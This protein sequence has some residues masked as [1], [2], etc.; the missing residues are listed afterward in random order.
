MQPVRFRAGSL[1]DGLP[2]RDL[3]VSPEHAM[4][5]DGVLVPARLLLNGD[6]IV[7]ETDLPTVEYFHVE[8]ASHDVLLA[9]GAPS[10]TF[11]DCDSRGMFQNAHTFAGDAPRWSFCA[12]RVEDG[13]VLARINE[14]LRLRVHAAAPAAAFGHLDWATHDGCAG[15]AWVPGHPEATLEVEVLVD[16]SP[17]ARAVANAWRPDV[18]AQGLGTGRYG[19]SLTFA[20]SLPRFRRHV[21][22]ARAVTGGDLIGAAQLDAAP[23]F[24][25]ASLPALAAAL[26]AH[27][28]TRE[29]ARDVTRFLIE[30]LHASRNARH[31]RS[32]APLAL[33]L[34]HAVPRPTE[35]AGSAAIV[36]HM[37]SL[38][39]LGYQVAFVPLD[40]SS[41][42]LPEGVACA[43]WPE[44]P[45]VEDA[46]RQ[47]GDAALVY[48]HRVTSM[49][50]YG[51]L[52]RQACPGARLVYAV[53]D[54]HFLRLGRQAVVEHSA[55]RLAESRRSREQELAAS[56]LAD[57]TLTH[58]AAE[59]ELL[60]RLLPGISARVV[61]WHVP[62]GPL[63]YAW[64]RRRNLLFVGGLAH[65]PNADALRWLASEI[66]PRI[67]GMNPRLRCK[68]VGVGLTE[69][70]R[71]W[72]HPAMDV[73][74][75]VQ[76]I[77]RVYRSA[78]V[79]LAPLRFGAGVKGKVLE[80]FA[81]I[82]P[83]AMTPIAAEGL[84]LPEALRPLVAADADAFAQLVVALHD[85]PAAN[86]AAGE[87]GRALVTR[88]TSE[89]V[90]DA[91][92]A[93][94]AASARA[95]RF[96]S[97]GRYWRPACQGSDEQVDLQIRAQPGGVAA[98]MQMS[99][100]SEHIPKPR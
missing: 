36:S 13:P 90:V 65:A 86:Q 8:L 75:P 85:D 87:A 54:L 47:H 71:A 53:A 26:Q 57:V 60:R 64:R 92:L 2:R 93:N 40:G 67:A 99:S 74:G 68:L 28:V 88:T 77:S 6:T 78:R 79:A 15:W 66:M 17:M 61:P 42:P 96:G 29:G 18:K 95:L 37:Q 43:A 39:R 59:E 25:P 11:V 69:A 12:P 35:D 10:E 100:W 56:R 94:V 34:D 98:G 44:F 16:G 41:G 31:R 32:T 97:R 45:N 30:Q 70:D 52:I 80:A 20:Q 19:F 38:Q 81:A 89:P 63:P 24:D 51:P 91:A 21:V 7:Q 5:L 9:E 14:R 58:S 22:T 83:C 23:K 76:D 62:P 3:L 73:L 50:L 55:A 33:V 1:G 46:L 82:L 49:T 48:V 4:V 72:L 84:D 27:A